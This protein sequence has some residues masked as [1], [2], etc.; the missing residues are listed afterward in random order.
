[1]LQFLRVNL[2]FNNFCTNNFWKRPK[3]KCYQIVLLQIE[4]YVKKKKSINRIQPKKQKYIFFV[5]LKDLRFLLTVNKSNIGGNIHLRLHFGELLNQKLT[6][7]NYYK[8]FMYTL[9]HYSNVSQM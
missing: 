8:M 1:M 3:Y 4:K 6:F 7:V 9:R 5:D 2:F